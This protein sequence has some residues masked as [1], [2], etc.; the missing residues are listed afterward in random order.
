MKSFGPRAP[1]KNITKDRST[2]SDIH[3]C[4]TTGYMIMIEMLSIS[5]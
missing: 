1:L 4:T 3:P 5:D 2:Y